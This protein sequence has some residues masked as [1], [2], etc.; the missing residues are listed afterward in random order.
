MDRRG[1]VTESGWDCR[2]SVRIG[3]GFC[4]FWLGPGHKMGAMIAAGNIVNK[5]DIEYQSDRYG[6]HLPG[7]YHLNK[8]SR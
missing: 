3:S 1:D 8:Q 5:A 4:F 2:F 7:L 6:N